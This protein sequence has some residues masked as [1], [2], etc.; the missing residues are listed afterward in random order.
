MKL[1][2]QIFFLLLFTLTVFKTSHAQV[3]NEL[4]QNLKT[5]LPIGEV[6]E[7]IDNQIWVV[8]QDTKGNHWFGSNGKGLFRYDGKTLK[9]FTTNDGLVDNTIRSVQEYKKGHI[10]IGTPRGISQFNGTVFTTLQVNK[11]SS[12]QWKLEPNDLWFSSYEKEVYRYDGESLFELTL[13]SQNLNEIF[14]NEPNRFTIENMNNPYAVYGIDKDS[15]G[16]LWFGT[17]EAGAFRYDGNLFLWFPEKELSILP[18]GRVPGVR[19]MIEDRNGDMWLS[20]FI[21]KYRVKDNQSNVTYEK[22]EGIDMTKGHFEDQIPYFNSGLTDKNGDL[23]MT[24]YTR[25]VWKFDGETL[26]HLPV[27][28]GDAEILIVSIYQDNQGLIWLGTN[29]AGVY[30]FDGNNFKKF[31]P[32][33]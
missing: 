16:N 2:T 30:K 31:E 24:T 26:I 25:G 33:K 15:K 17:A 20:N 28:E 29:N 3:N 21:S 7:K 5:L 32:K 14:A 22:L 1:K 27:K 23:W 8:Y 9:V 12:H 18:D 10:F 6:V 4:L 19:S 13:P 11:S